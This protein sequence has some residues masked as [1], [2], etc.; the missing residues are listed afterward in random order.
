MH[1]TQETL[2]E[3]LRKAN[4]ASNIQCKLTPSS[5]RPNAGGSPDPGDNFLSLPLAY[6]LGRTGLLMEGSK[7]GW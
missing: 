7:G 4:E 5:L 3:I 2:L 6:N 1:T